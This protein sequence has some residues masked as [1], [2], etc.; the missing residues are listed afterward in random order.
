MMNISIILLIMVAVVI[1]AAVTSFVVSRKMRDK[2]AYMLDALEDKELNFR[3]DEKRLRG[4]KFNKTLNRLRNIFDKER[5]EIIEQEKYFGLMLDHVKTGV[6]VIEKDGRVNYCNSTALNLLGIATFGHI[7]QLRAVSDSLYD[8]FQT[9]ADGTE[10]KAS[11]YNES[12]KMTI[13]ITASQ[14]TIGKDI[15]RIIA[16]NDISSE[17]AENEQQSWSKLIRVLT[18]EIMNTITPIAS[19]SDT[20]LK[21]DGVSEDIKNGLSTISQSSKGLIKFV[22]SYRNLTRVAPPV[23]KAFY[24]RELAERVI[25]LT[26][27]QALTSGAVCKY[28]EQSEDIILYADEGQITQILINLVKNAIQ[29]E[30]RNIKITA[31]ITLSEQTIITVFNDGTPI[32]RESQDEIF[33][34]FFTTKQEGTGIGLSLSR[35][36]MRMHNGTLSLTRSDNKGTIFT[37]L[38]K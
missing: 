10:E 19:L 35:Q 37:L 2:V 34:P 25:N 13:S 27:D 32:S 4:R 29:A 33:V 20:L 15:V 30:A 12:G 23:R 22:E 8:A 1:T 18:H 21:F 17:I 24:F 26:K 36:I 31:Q 11:Y 28:K 38:F 7:R 3:F 14:A 5:H 6:A 9:I 16:F